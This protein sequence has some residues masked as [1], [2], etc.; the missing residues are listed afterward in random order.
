MTMREMALL[1]EGNGNERQDARA[2]R[3]FGNPI[4]SVFFLLASRRLGVHSHRSYMIKFA[5]I[6]SLLLASIASAQERWTIQTGDFRSRSAE[7]I[8][9]DDQNVVTSDGTS[10]V[11][12]PLTE[13]LSLNKSSARVKPAGRWLL[14]LANG[15][16]LTGEPVST[17]GETIVW[18]GAS[19]GEVSIPMQQL[20]LM[21]PTK[22]EAKPASGVSKEDTVLLANGDR[23]AGVIANL[24]DKSITVSAANGPIDVP[25]D[26]INSV[27]FASLAPAKESLP[28]GFRLATNDGAR[29]TV[30]QLAESNNQLSFTLRDGKART[31]DLASVVSIEQLNGPVV[32]LSSLPPSE[33]VHIPYFD[34]HFDNQMDRT[35]TGG[36]IRFKERTFARGIGVHSYSR[37]TWKISG[38]FRAFRTQ[39]AIDGDCPLADVTV[40]IK[41][42]DK[43][44]HEAA[45]F[46]A[47]HLSD[48]VEIELKGVAAITLEVDY[49]DGYDVQDHLNWIEP[50]LLRKS[51]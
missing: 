38:D 25:L 15:D 10:E 34:A 37:L 16:Q 35:T 43:V 24:N 8:R 18:K 28:R 21:T 29:L 3:K 13:F 49:G 19:F 40:R 48:P 9:I 12:I 4:L 20:R 14:L 42:G 5:F 39:Y 51:R 7:L 44:L 2:P 22:M 36:A 33:S 32:W 47:G 46:R 50:A 6:L 27:Q 45:H 26:S 17:R 31:L 30:T 41:S 1:T 11:M 23:V